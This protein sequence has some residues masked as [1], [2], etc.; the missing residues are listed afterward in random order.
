MRTQWLTFL[1]R[2]ALRDLEERAAVRAT[3]SDEG[4]PEDA[5]VLNAE[6]AVALAAFSTLSD[7]DRHLIQLRFIDGLDHRQV[8]AQ[9][10]IT[11]EAARQRVCRA[12]DR[13]VAACVALESN[14]GSGA[15]RHVRSRLAEYVTG[16]LPKRSRGALESHLVVCQDCVNL[17][18][19]LL[20]AYP[21]AMTRLGG[22][23]VARS[24]WS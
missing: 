1:R 20:D 17:M 8:A 2:R 12:R 4:S 14:I 18:S 10:D 24:R 15:C 11:V 6:R 21:R 16:S 23:K 5:A 22:R 13:L 7:G 19:D 3:T 9:L